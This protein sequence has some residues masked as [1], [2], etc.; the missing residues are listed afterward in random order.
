VTIDELLT[1]EEHMLVQRLGNIAS[2]F[3]WMF[4][5]GWDRAEFVGHI[6]ACQNAVLAQAAARAF[7]HLYRNIA[8]PREESDVD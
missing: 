8:E 3:C 2:T 1:E 7:P 4:T 6:H 5:D